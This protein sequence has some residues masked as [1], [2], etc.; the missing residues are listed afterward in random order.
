MH[1]A[2][3][4]R[5][6][7]CVAMVPTPEQGSR[8]RPCQITVRGTLIIYNAAPVLSY[9]RAVPVLSDKSGASCR[10]NNIL[11]YIA[12]QGKVINTPKTASERQSF[13]TVIKPF[14]HG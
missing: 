11:P 12:D 2:K 6:Q 1:G 9:P 13:T 14:I 7:K 4:P 10:T 3:V 8:A 5:N